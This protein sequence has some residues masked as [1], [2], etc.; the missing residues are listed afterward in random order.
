MNIFSDF[1]LRQKFFD[2]TVWAFAE[3]AVSL[4]RKRIHVPIIYVKPSKHISFMNKKTSLPNNKQ[5][6]PCN[7]KR[8]EQIIE[9]KEQ[10]YT[11]NGKATITPMSKDHLMGIY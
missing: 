3:K 10:S 4:C 7:A 6:S 11:D 2:L 9:P 5:T 1:H 8:D